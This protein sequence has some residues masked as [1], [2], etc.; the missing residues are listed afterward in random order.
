MERGPIKEVLD[1]GVKAINGMLTIGRGQR[2][3]LVAGSGVGKSVL[4]GMMTRFNEADVVALFERHGFTAIDP[5]QH[6]FEEQV[7][8]AA[9]AEVLAGPYGAN[10]ANM[11]FA[12]KARKLLILGT[13][14]QPEFARLA[15]ALGIP[16]WNTVP[17]G[18]ELR[19]GRTLSESFGYMADLNALERLLRDSLA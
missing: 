15:S 13:K 9:E 6:S 17:Q 7:K 3:G 10:L 14:H 16:F 8:Y 19:Q 18:V 4:L 5:E 11:V 12:G 1:V 2:L